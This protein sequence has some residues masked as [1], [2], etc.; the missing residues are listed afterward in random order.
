MILNTFDN[1]SGGSGIDVIT[2]TGSSRITLDT[3]CFAFMVT[4]LGSTCTISPLYVIDTIKSQSYYTT[5]SIIGIICNY[6]PS[7]SVNSAD[8]LHEYMGS[9]KKSTNRVDLESSSY[10]LTQFIKS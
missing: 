6:Q 9:Y 8:D 10:Y 7:N 4:D 5:M 1:V 3:K 2:T